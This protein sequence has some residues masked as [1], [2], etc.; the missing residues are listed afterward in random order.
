LYPPKDTSPP[1]VSFAAF[2]SAV[3]SAASIDA[4][5]EVVR[6][7][8]RDQLH[9]E[10]WVAEWTGHRWA[11]QAPI[12]PALDEIFTR[13]CTG[14]RCTDFSVHASG[15]SAITVV[16]LKEALDSPLVLVIDGDWTSIRQPLIDGVQLLALALR[17]TRE[18]TAKLDIANVLVDGYARIRRLSRLGSME[19]VA[20]RVVKDVAAMLGAT[21]VSLALYRPDAGGLT[22]VATEGFSLAAVKDVRIM[23]GDWVIGHVYS[24]GRPVLVRDVNVLPSLASTPARYRTASFAAVPMLAGAE[25]VGVITVTDK[26]DGHAFS[27]RDELV[28]RTLS[29]AAAVAMVAARSNSEV[30]RLEHA[31]TIDSLTGLL[32]RPGFD[33]RIHEEIQRKRREAGNLAVLMADVDDFKTINDTRGHPVGDEV[34]KLVAQVIRSSVRVF[35]LCARYGGDEF[36]VVMPNS[37]RENA[38]QCAERIRRRLAERA[39]DDDLGRVSISIGV[40]VLVPGDDASDLLARADQCLYRAKADGKNVVRADPPEL[41]ALTIANPI[42][43]DPAWMDT[44]VVAIED[45]RARHL[46]T[47]GIP[48]ASAL[49]YVLVVDSQSDRAALCLEASAPFQI[50]FLKARDGQQAM[51][52]IDRFGAPVLLVVDLSL[53]VNHGFELVEHLRGRHGDRSEV[54]AWAASREIRE[55]ASARLRDCGLHVIAGD[56]SRAMVRG[57]IER[58]LERQAPPPRAE[59]V[60]SALTAEQIQRVIAEL[61]YEARQIVQAAGVAVYLQA[62][63]EQAYRATFSWESDHPIPSSTTSLPRAFHEIAAH[64]RSV[65][66]PAL[67]PAANAAGTGDALRGLVGVP[68]A[69]DG[70]VLGALCVFDIVPISMSHGQI[71]ALE[72]LGRAVIGA[73]APDPASAVALALHTAPPAAERPATT[74]INRPSDWPAGLLERVGGE[75]AVARELTRARREGVDLSVA[76][77]EIGPLGDDIELEQSIAHASD[78][79]LKTIRQSDLPIRWSGHEF[80]VV[81]PGLSGAVARAVAERVRAALQAAAHEGVAV[82]GIVTKLQGDESCGDVVSR[83]RARARITRGG[84]HNRIVE[85]S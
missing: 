23:P 13:N 57:A 11:V 65:Y 61:T 4:A 59:A 79:L 85:M 7:A 53:P 6:D 78:T 66:T 52:I 55:Y 18:R 34:L 1:D 60:R 64:G 15:S 2:A 29:A 38:I 51:G 26:H 82:A 54:V 77:F 14:D 36:G 75:F 37:D 42:A 70:E 83:V 10:S 73:I 35:D 20:Q 81:L 63:G 46:A 12:A 76:L 58:A 44:R 40:T 69:R 25:A 71:V 30:R 32:N 67:T 31:A 8:I 49:R 3:V 48:P 80:V 72:R 16:P 84:G 68:I 28:L 50:G 24:S 33:H 39:I 41:A 56:A 19:E 74:L 45:R 62:P 5:Y 17:V 9:A 21:R 22:I 47:P 43:D 27:R